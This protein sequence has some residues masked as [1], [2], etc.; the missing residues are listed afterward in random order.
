VSGAS[1]LLFVRSDDMGR[2][3]TSPHVILTSPD[4]L[5][6]QYQPSLEVNAGGVVGVS[7]FNALH[8]T[9]ATS[10]MFAVS[11]DGGASF[12]TPARISSAASP[13]D[14]PNGGDFVA[15]AFPDPHGGFV[16]LTSPLKRFP[17]LGDYMYLA[18]DGTGAF[19]PVWIDA[20][21]GASQV[22]TATVFPSAPD[23]APANLTVRKLSDLTVLEMGVGSWDGASHTL[24]VPVRLHNVSEKVLYPPVTVSVTMTQSPYLKANPDLSNPAFARYIPPVL[25]LNADNH[26]SGLGASFVYSTDT[27]GD[28]GRLLPGADTAS[29]TWKFRIPSSTYEIIFV[30]SITGYVSP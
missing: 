4:A 6:A 17:S 27:L 11:R 2:H 15:Q 24:T 26:R 25:I 14:P 20:R 18:V 16:W 23:A 22:W 8:A 10:E 28:L 9:R 1:R 19:H 3:W 30:T 12:S 29:R 13:I 5:D 7:F 21:T